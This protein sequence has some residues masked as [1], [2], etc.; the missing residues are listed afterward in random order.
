MM[1]GGEP[2]TWWQSKY[3]LPHNI[4]FS[5]NKNFGADPEEGKPPF[6]AMQRV[7]ICW[8]LVRLYNN[9]DIMLMTVM[10]LPF[11]FTPVLIK[12][13]YSWGESP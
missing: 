4:A 8:A 12:Q 2:R 6:R 1:G 3:W 10:T 5:D 9:D 13:S 7:L 11:I